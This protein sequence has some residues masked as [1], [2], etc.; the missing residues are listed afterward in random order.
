MIGE[1]RMLETIKDELVEI[2]DLLYQEDVQSAYQKLSMVIPKMME[3]LGSVEDEESK[4]LLIT[5]LSSALEAM[6]NEDYLL[7]ADVIQYEL[8]ETLEQI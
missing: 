5:K 6:E 3:A 8:L 2:A 1:E 4:N 7:L